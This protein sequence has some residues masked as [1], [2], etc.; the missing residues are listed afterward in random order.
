MQKAALGFYLLFIS[1][2]I[3]S[4]ST[5]LGI[6]SNNEGISFWS[7]SLKYF[8]VHYQSGKINE[9]DYQVAIHRISSEITIMAG[10]NIETTYPVVDSILYSSMETADESMITTENSD[11]LNPET[12]QTDFDISN[13]MPEEPM[14]VKMPLSARILTAVVP[15]PQART[16]S[17]ISMGFG[18]NTLNNSSD[19][20]RPTIN[21]YQNFYI[22]HLM[23]NFRTRLGNSNSKLGIVY[24]IGFDY[25]TFKQKENWKTLINNNGKPSFENTVSINSLDEV[26]LRL[27]Y[28]RIPIG[29]DFKFTKNYSLQ[30]SGFYNL[31]VRQRQYTTTHNTNDDKTRIIESKDFGLNKHL[32]GIHYQFAWRRFYA[33]TEHNLNSILNDNADHELGFVKFGVGIR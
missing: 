12:E 18:F 24:G 25:L 32:F 16:K 2:N 4:Q 27:K 33:F 31:L 11:S 26:K 29:L 15:K 1:L 10:N 5:I 28:L 30:I 20:H 9:I 23:I 17:G 13:P 19:A 14:K 6:N 8:Q 22:D 3:Y 21:W 7:D